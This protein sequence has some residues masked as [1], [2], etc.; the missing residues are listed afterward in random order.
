MTEPIGILGYGIEGQS[1]LTWLLA[2]GHREIVVFDRKKPEQLP[3]GIAYGGEGENYLAGLSAMR[4]VFRSAGVRPDAPEIQAFVAAGGRLTS[5]IETAFAVAGKQRIIGVTGTLGKGTACSLLEAM[6]DKAGIPC[7]LAGNIGTPALDAA[8]SLPEGALLLLEL[9]S[10]Q[11]STLSE[12]PHRAAV[13]R[14]TVEHLDWHLSRR[15]YWEHKSNLVRW[16]NPEDFLV[17][18]SDAEGSRLIAQRSAA[19]RKR[20]YG[21]E[22]GLLLRGGD[23][24][25][26]VR[27]GKRLHA[28]EL[29]MPGSFNLENVAAAAA[30]ALDCGAPFE[31]IAEAARTFAGLEHRLEK[32]REHRGIAYY[33]DSYATRPE[34]TQ[35]AVS[36]LSKAP[37]GLILGG[38]DK[39]V[40]FLP[41]ARH[42]AAAPHLKAIALIGATADR[43]QENL[44]TSG[45]QASLRLCEGLGDSVDFLRAQL[46][47]GGAI[48]LSPACASFGLFAN[49]KERGRLFK[50]LIG[51][52][53]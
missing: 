23:A 37:L 22:G 51:N 52:L 47:E 30:L 3:P 35:G 9:S 53:G 13:L 18:C 50:Q 36:A 11:L 31:A 38:S 48:A 2:R 16:Q 40:D 34:A 39:Q 27:E 32:V 29:Q 43:L 8:E 49:Y 24:L 41:L 20:S 25:E 12:S 46:P 14:T 1:S 10:F 26:F 6:L 15:E 45:C 44:L 21:L 33:N 42:L 7:I 17:F 19:K 5:Q 28:D 4:T